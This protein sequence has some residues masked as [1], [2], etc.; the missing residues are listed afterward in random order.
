[1]DFTHIIEF[2]RNN[3]HQISHAYYEQ[4]KKT[5]LMK[6]YR[7]LSEK[8]VIARE[9]RVFENLIEWLQTGASNDKAEKYFENVGAERFKEG[10]PLTEVN[11]AL[12]IT[13]KVFWSFIAWKKELFGFDDEEGGIDFS[14]IMEYVTILNNF[15]DLGNFYI[16]RGYIGELF[17]QLEETASMSKEEIKKILMHGAFDDNDFNKDEIIWHHI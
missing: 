16:I 6:N 1:M 5:E 9:E 3:L 12:Y 11:Y 17:E 15:F 14:R 10:F 4:I 2:I 7:R 8:E 13:K